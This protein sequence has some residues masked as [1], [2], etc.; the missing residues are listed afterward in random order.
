MVRKRCLILVLLLIPALVFAQNTQKQETRKAALQKEIE[1][2]N[3]QLKENSRSNAKALS[4]LQLVRRKIDN[5]R[6]CWRKAIWKSR[7]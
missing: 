1:V 6:N 5:R 3:R 2:I 4:S 7:P